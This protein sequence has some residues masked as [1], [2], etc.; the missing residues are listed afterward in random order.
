[1]PDQRGG[2]DQLPSFPHPLGKQLT[3]GIAQFDVQGHLAGGMGA[4]GEAR[5]EATGA[6]LAPVEQRLGDLGISA[7]RV[8]DEFSGD[9]GHGSVYG[10]YCSGRWR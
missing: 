6:C 5:V 2:V 8:G 1:V 4:A 7:H 3:S 10:E 9:L